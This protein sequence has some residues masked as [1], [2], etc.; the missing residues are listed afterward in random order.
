MKWY[1]SSTGNHQGL[2]CSE[3]GGE[4]IAVSYDKK[5]ADLIAAAPELLAELKDALRIFERDR[6]SARP[7]QYRKIRD[8]IAKAEGKE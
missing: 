2:I 1:K 3:D 5:D 7:E 6:V 8:V 4:N